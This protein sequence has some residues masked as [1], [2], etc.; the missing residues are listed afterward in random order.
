MNILVVSYSS[1]VAEL[2]KLVFKGG[3][4]ESEN[5]RNSDSAKYD[6]YDVIFIDDSVPNLQEEI[7]VIKDNFSYKKIILLGSSKSSE[8]L[9]DIV[10]K[11]PFLPKDIDSVLKSIEDELSSKS[12]SAVL[13]IEEIEKIK[14]LMNLDSE[15]QEEEEEDYIDLID[16]INRRES[17]KIKGKEAREFLYDCRGLTKKELKKLL[18]S[19]KVT[20]KI[21]FK[22]DRYE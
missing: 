16:R 22:R 14:A 8:N 18:K 4:I 21:E 10:V 11:K 12:E 13:N 3:K 6:S 15:T 19:A 5:I 2:L 1:T 7:E 9:V 20:I 17:L